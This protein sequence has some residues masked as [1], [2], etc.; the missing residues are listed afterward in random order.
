M[1]KVNGVQDAVAV[2]LVA[3]DTVLAAVNPMDSSRQMPEKIVTANKTTIQRLTLKHDGII[4]LLFLLG[5]Q[6]D[7]VGDDVAGCCFCFCSI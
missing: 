2:D 6:P 3:V 1:R 4:V 5:I 7:V